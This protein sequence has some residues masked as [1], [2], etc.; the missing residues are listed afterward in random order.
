MQKP[1]EAAGGPG[2]YLRVDIA[3]DHAQFPTWK[4]PV[5][6]YFVRQAAGWKLVGLERQ[7][8]PPPAKK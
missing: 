7:V 6:A 5:Q 3:T 8:T 2:S 1:A 4:Q